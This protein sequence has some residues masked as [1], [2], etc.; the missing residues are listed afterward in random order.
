MAQQPRDNLN[1]A[2]KAGRRPAA[3]TATASVLMVL[4]LGSSVGGRYGRGL[5][6]AEA[7]V[8]PS[9]TGVGVR[10]LPFAGASTA[11]PG[12]VSVEAR[13]GVSMSAVQVGVF[14]VIDKGV[15]L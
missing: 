7:F 5:Q 13:R 4:A 9:L 15:F 6:G 11:R 1:H 3:A 2:R 12:L 8:T 14:H 10:R